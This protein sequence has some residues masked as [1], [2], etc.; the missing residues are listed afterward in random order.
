MRS[1]SKGLLALILAATILL[2]SDLQ[3]RKK[4]TSRD[5]SARQIHPEAIT[6][7]EYTLGLCYFAPEA[8]H[9]EL[10]KGVWT[11]LEELGYFRDSN[12]IIKESHANGEIGNISPILLNLDNQNQIKGIINLKLHSYNSPE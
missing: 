7:K 12:L 1:I 3:N 10:L 6:G 4:T 11:R 5:S 2:V 9:D 8:A